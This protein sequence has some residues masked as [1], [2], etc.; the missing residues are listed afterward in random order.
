MG[1]ASIL[2]SITDGLIFWSL[3]ATDPEKRI[4]FSRDEILAKIEGAIPTARKFIRGKIDERLKLLR[5]KGNPQGRQ[6]SW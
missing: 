2:I 1:N 6:I 3:E 4:L 5:S